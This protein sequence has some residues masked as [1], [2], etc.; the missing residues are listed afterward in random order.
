M[1]SARLHDVLLIQCRFG[2]STSFY[3][4]NTHLGVLVD[5]TSILYFAEKIKRLAFNHKFAMKEL[6]LFAVTVFPMIH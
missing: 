6:L 3:F 1:A 5:L 2:F 4:K